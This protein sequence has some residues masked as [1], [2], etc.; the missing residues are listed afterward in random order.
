MYMHHMYSSTELVWVGAP[1]GTCIPAYGLWL[2]RVGEWEPHGFMKFNKCAHLLSPMDRLSSLRLA[3]KASSALGGLHDVSEPFALP[4]C[5]TSKVTCPH[6]RSRDQSLR[7]S[8][9]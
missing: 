4:D 9:T 6:V 3:V 2:T 7:Q 1:T 5:P 8:S